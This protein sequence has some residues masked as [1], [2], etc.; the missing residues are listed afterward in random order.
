MS[1]TPNQ[2]TDPVYPVIP[3]VA[4]DP[5]PLAEFGGEFPMKQLGLLSIQLDH[6]R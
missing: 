2:K 3:V 4:N 5:N 1:C 6:S